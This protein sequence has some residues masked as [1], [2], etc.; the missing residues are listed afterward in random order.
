MKINPYIFRGYDIRGLVGED[1]NP[2]IVEH[3]GRAH[4]TILGKLG[5]KKAIVGH[6]CRQT[7]LEYSKAVIKGLNWAGIDVVFIGMEMVGTFYWSQY[8]LNS[9]GGVYV[10]ASH[11]PKQ[12]NGFKL[13][14]DF[15]ET[16]VSEG[17]QELRKIVEEENYV[18]GENEGTVEEKNIR[19]DYFDDILKRF[20]F[21]NKFKIV[22]D[23]SCSTAGEIVPQ[24]LRQAGFEVV[25]KNCKI[26][27]TF[28]LGTPDP[29]E[30]VVA[31]RLSEEVIEETADVGLSYDADGDRMG[32]VD[33]KGGIIWNDVLVA[34]FA[35]G[36][37]KKHPGDKIMFNTLCS[38]VVED[39]IK[40]EGGVPFMWRTGHSFLKKKNQEVKAAFVGELSGHFFF[41]KDFYNHDDGIYSS[42]YLLEYL[43]K[44]GQSLAE[45]VNSLPKYI[46]S[47]E[48]KLFCT[49]EKK[50]DLINKLIPVLQKDFPDA[51]II[52]DQ[53]AGD[54]LRLNLDYGMFVVRYSQNGPY[55]TI[56][57]EAKEQEKYEYLKKYIKNLLK[58][59]PEI[60]WNPK[61]NVNTEAFE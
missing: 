59:Y 52:T 40:N 12:Y 16:M 21:V 14:I 22:V 56:K 28:P 37:L 23:P 18:K 54:G 41:S 4:G 8:F 36:V 58:K 32:I 20:E 15:S 7:S 51:E 3:I 5:I 30:M 39:T 31:K 34:L 42:L 45:A 24:I 33:G 19:Q 35:K 6:D 27:P 61:I 47:P 60:D 48:I 46:S 44:T 49:D 29:T 9:K 26:D 43:G 55:L 11:N 10:T 25:E 17:I 1:L 57:F 50:V 38:K 13:A 2:E 53:R